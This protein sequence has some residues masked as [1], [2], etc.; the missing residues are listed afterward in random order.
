MQEIERAYKYACNNM[1]VMENEERIS[2]VSVAGAKLA[3]RATLGTELAKAS[4]SLLRAIG[5]AV[6]IL[7]DESVLEDIRNGRSEEREKASE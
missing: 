6:A 3:I 7:L 5:D 2:V 1:V 4:D